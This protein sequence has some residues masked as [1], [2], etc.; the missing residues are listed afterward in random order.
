MEEG[1]IRGGKGAAGEN[2][3]TGEREGL[4]EKMEFGRRRN[5][6]RGSAGSPSRSR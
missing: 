5:W 3:G 1:K 2:E 6:G 4:E